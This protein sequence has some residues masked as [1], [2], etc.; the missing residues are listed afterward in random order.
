LGLEIQALALKSGSDLMSAPK[1]TV[2]SGKRANIVV[3]QELRFPQSY[4]DIESTVSGSEGSSSIS[5]T[6][7][8]PQDFTSRNVGVEMSV[9]PNVENNNTISLILEPRVTE[10]EGFVEYG[11]PSIAIGGEQSAV[12][13][14]GFF[15]PV[16]S[17]REITTEVTIYDGATVVMGGLTRDEVKSVNDKVPFLGDIP[18][19]GRLFRSEGETR[20]KRNL[21]IFVTANLVSPGGSLTNQSYDN[22]KSNTTYQSPALAI[23]AG[24]NFRNVGISE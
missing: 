12:V 5:I 7:G 9:T 17:T 18:G 22:I 8:T 1:V 14:S 16:F 19:L 3:A 20:Q 11:G 6:A 21:L 23:P 10:F 13:P 4:G 2:L 24:N 15:Q